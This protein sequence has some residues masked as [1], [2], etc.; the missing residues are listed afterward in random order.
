[1]EWFARD[2]SEMVGRSDFSEVPECG[3]PPLMWGMSA[4]WSGDCWVW[5]GVLQLD[6]EVVLS[7]LI[8]D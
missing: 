8:L 5:S 7:L 2:N 1:M 4:E 3:Q 6:L